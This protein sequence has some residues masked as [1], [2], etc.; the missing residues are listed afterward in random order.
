MN[1]IYLVFIGIQ[2]PIVIQEKLKPIPYPFYNINFGKLNTRDNRMEIYQ[3]ILDNI[4][5]YFLFIYQ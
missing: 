4:Y 3:S 1:N 5:N 2:Q